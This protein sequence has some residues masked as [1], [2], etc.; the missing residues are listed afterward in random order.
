MARRLDALVQHQER[1]PADPCHQ[2]QIAALVDD[3]HRRNPPVLGSDASIRVRTEGPFIAIEPSGCMKSNLGQRSIMNPNGFSVTGSFGGVLAT[4]P[5]KGDSLT[6]WFVP[7]LY[8]QPGIGFGL[9]HDDLTLHAGDG[10][11]WQ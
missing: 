11:M 1:K 4:L 7:A 2:A 3:K 10:R 9:V 5:E 8:R 6:S